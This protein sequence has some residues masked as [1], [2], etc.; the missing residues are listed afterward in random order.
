MTMAIPNPGRMYAQVKKGIVAPCKDC[1]DR[2]PK[3]HGDCGKYSEYLQLLSDTKNKVFAELRREK[4]S[5]Q[6]FY[7][8]DER[9]KKRLEHK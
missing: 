6:Y 1:P 4:D 3:C 7:Q 8:R 9:I 2:H 5:C